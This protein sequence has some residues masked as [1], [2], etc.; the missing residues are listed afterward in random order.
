MANYTF[1]L[2][3]LRPFPNSLY[4][5]FQPAIIKTLFEKLPEF[6]FERYVELL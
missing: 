3:I 1:L 5:L 6:L 4:L 2:Y